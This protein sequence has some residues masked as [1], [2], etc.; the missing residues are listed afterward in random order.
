MAV[1]Y[2]D[3]IAKCISLN[4]NDCIGFEISLN[5]VPMGSIDTTPVLVQVMA[6]RRMG[7]AI[8]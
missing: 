5:C 7:Q 1:A 2:A 6:W 4:E 3:D 8:T